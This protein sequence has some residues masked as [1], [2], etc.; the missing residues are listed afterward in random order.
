MNNWTASVAV[1]FFG[2]YALLDRRPNSPNRCPCPAILPAGRFVVNLVCRWPK[3]LGTKNKAKACTAAFFSA[4]I[5]IGCGSKNVKEEV[6][7]GDQIDSDLIQWEGF[8]GPSR[9]ISGCNCSSG[10]TP[11]DTLATTW[12]GSKSGIGTSAKSYIQIDSG[13]STGISEGNRIPSRVTWLHE[14]TGNGSRQ[15]WPRNSLR[16]ICLPV[17]DVSL[18]PQNPTLSDDEQKTEHFKIWLESIKPFWLL[19]LGVFGAWHGFRF[20]EKGRILFGVTLLAISYFLCLLF[21]PL[22]TRT[23][24]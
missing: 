17:N 23:S 9:C 1:I 8:L 16:Y 22:L 20:L 14:K 6:L 7:V 24:F 12:H 13:Y 4:I 18:T 21:W 11:S 19:I 5:L 15:I 3:V 2:D 10:R